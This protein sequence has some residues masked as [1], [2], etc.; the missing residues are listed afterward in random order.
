[1][2]GYVGKS[3][4]R[5]KTHESSKELFGKL[6]S[7]FHVDQYQASTQSGP[8]HQL[9]EF[10]RESL[11]FLLFLEANP[12]N[13]SIQLN[14]S[15]L[16][17]IMKYLE[18]ENLNKLTSELTDT[19]LG[20][21][22]IINGRIEAFIMKRAGT[23]KKY[24]HALGER[25]IAEME[26]AEN[27]LATFQQFQEHLRPMSRKRSQSTGGI[28]ESF[29][30]VKHQ[31]IDAVDDVAAK[32]EAKRPRAASFD[33]TKSTESTKLLSNSALG[34]FQE[35]STRRLMTDLIL[36][37]NASFPD[38]DFGSVR[39]KDFKKVPLD[40]VMQA[41][42]NRLSLL[43]S[44]KEGFLS[45][46]WQSIDNVVTLSDSHV[47]TFIP[48]RDDLSF[49]TQT[50][51]EDDSPPLWSFNYFFVNK[52]MKRILFFCCVETM[53]PTDEEMDQFVTKRVVY[54]EQKNE[55]NF[56]LD[57]AADVAGGIALE[58]VEGTMML[59]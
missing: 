54:S 44:H 34:D 40:V 42:N 9:F 55:S 1:M 23:D 2:F 37:L 16:N 31:R 26:L 11:P 10:Q 48:P 14:K 21:S 17:Y 19:V 57:P 8:E 46:L 38:Y 36:T 5:N 49:L 53:Q 43:A 51:A 59:S 12:T 50:L 15:C 27:Q 4:I 13:Y 33:S 20:D 41:V 35:M 58:A 39:A 52:Q 24:A 28:L 47:Y 45:Q 32:H 56:D 7:C 3:R 29:G 18:D 6:T 25:Y 30:P 22:R